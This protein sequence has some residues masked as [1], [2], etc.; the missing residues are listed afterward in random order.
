[1]N[2]IH[3]VTEHTETRLVIVPGTYYLLSMYTQYN[4]YYFFIVVIYLYRKVDKYYL[5]YIYIIYIYK[6]HMI[7]GHIH[8]HKYIYIYT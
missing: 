8:I 4:K 7:C 6:S 5:I 3:A 2:Q 1:M